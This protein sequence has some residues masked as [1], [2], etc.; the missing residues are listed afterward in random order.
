[1]AVI[2]A[3]KIATALDEIKYNAADCHGKITAKPGDDLMMTISFKT[4]TGAF[5]WAADFRLEDKV[6]LATPVSTLT[7]A[8][9]LLVNIADYIALDD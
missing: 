2:T 5:N 6:R 9:V 1:M 3:E 8:A 7:E 4:A